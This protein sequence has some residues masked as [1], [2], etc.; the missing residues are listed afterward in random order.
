MVIEPDKEQRVQQTA[1]TLIELIVVVAII[2]ILIS[3]LLPALA[4]AKNEAKRTNCKSNLRQ[5]GLAFAMYRGDHDS[6]FPDRRDLKL[7]LPGGYRPGRCSGGSGLLRRGSRTRRLIG[8]CARHALR[9]QA[10]LALFVDLLFAAQGRLVRV[11]HLGGGLD[12]TEIHVGRH[13]G[14]VAPGA[15]HRLQDVV[16]ALG[17]QR[18]HATG[19]VELLARH[20]SRG[21]SSPKYDH[22]SLN[23][24]QSAQQQN[25]L[26]AAGKALGS[27][28]QRMMDANI[29]MGYFL[30]GLFRVLALM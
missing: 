30:M 23:I 8:Q 11:E 18:F 16:H 29:A 17:E 2:A 6:R 27:E 1:F 20:G 22:I 28:I 4:K 13:F 19:V 9:R 15:Q 25:Q 14:L 3:L 5:I 26:T 21:L 7:S 12:R 24:W 10:A